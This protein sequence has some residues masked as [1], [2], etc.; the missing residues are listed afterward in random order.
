M[1]VASDTGIDGCGVSRLKSAENI[2]KDIIGNIGNLDS[3]KI[4]FDISRYDLSAKFKLSKVSKGIHSKTFNDFIMS[5]VKVGRYPILIKD[6]LK[7]KERVSDRHIYDLSMKIA[8]DN[9][10][11]KDF[12]IY[13]LVKELE[14]ANKIANHDSLSQSKAE[15]FETRIHCFNA[16]YKNIFSN[17]DAQLKERLT[18]AIRSEKDIA[19]LVKIYPRSLRLSAAYIVFGLGGLFI[20]LYSSALF[21]IDSQ[22]SL[23]GIWKFIGLN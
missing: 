15:R 20:V 12:V 4:T 9:D 17:A 21:F 10:L 16:I 19:D 7:G 18:H 8:S 3:S 11:L 1:S 5:H 6:I 13:A 22:A 14:A 2:E 23:L